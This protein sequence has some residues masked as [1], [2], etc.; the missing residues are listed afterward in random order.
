VK[1]AILSR[2]QAIKNTVMNVYMKPTEREKRIM[3]K[4][5]TAKYFLLTVR[6]VELNVVHTV[7]V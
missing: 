5:P 2:L 4:R 6:S 3:R 7:P 1:N